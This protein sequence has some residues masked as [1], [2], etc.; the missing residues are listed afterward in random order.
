METRKVDDDKLALLAEKFKEV[1]AEYH[2]LEQGFNHRPHLQEL[3][4]R[5]TYLFSELSEIIKPTKYNK[6]YTEKYKDVLLSEEILRV[7][8]EENITS[9]AKCEKMVKAD[10]I[11]KDYID[12]MAHHD[13]EW[14]YVKHFAESIKQYIFT[15]ASDI[16]GINEPKA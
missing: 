13:S 3:R 7:S 1:R 8:S 4:K 2:S 15:L 11:Y 14:E 5:M 12:V 6:I 9:I 16:E 10:M